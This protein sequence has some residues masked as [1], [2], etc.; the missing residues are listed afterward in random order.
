MEVAPEVQAAITNGSMLLPQAGNTK[1]ILELAMTN[2]NIRTSTSTTHQIISVPVVKQTYRPLQATLPPS[3][4]IF[5]N[6]GSTIQSSQNVLPP[7]NICKLLDL[8]SLD[9]CTVCTKFHFI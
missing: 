9:L 6:Q 7:Q 4:I 1:N 8:P 2:S 3:K 5:V